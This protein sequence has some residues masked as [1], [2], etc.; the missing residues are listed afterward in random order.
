MDALSKEN[1]FDHQTLTVLLKHHI[2]EHPKIREQQD[3][4]IRDK[5][6][7]SLFYEK[8][9][10]KYRHDFAKLISSL[11]RKY[12]IN[13]ATALPTLI[14]DFLNWK[15]TVDIADV[16]A[17]GIPEKEELDPSRAEF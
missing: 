11:E 1:W 15:E 13:D 12:K 6:I 14:H 9:A 3:K 4:R 7:D 8:I 16:F 2:Y 5:Q 17:H 10:K